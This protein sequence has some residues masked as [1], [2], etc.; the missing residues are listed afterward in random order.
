M[1]GS[2]WLYFVGSVS[3][4]KDDEA[5]RAEN[6]QRSNMSAPIQTTKS[7]MGPIRAVKT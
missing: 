7:G 5:G 1:D 6:E 4:G 3:Q 2:V